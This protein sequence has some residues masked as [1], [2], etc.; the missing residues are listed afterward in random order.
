MSKLAS[1][2]ITSFADDNAKYALRPSRVF[3]LCAAFIRSTN[4]SCRGRTDYVIQDEEGIDE[5]VSGGS[6]LKSGVLGLWLVLFAVSPKARAQEEDHYHPEHAKFHNIYKG[7]V[8]SNGVSSCCNGDDPE[9]GTKGDCHPARAYLD[10]DD[11]LWRV[12]IKGKWLIVP[13]EAM[14]PYSTPDGNSHVCE[15]ES[16]GIMCFVGGQPK[17]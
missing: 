10:P 5:P 6:R 11:N 8:Q 13:P 1:S 15:D 7:W 2:F 9:L 14:R 12:L 4:R 17:S 3:Y 16:H